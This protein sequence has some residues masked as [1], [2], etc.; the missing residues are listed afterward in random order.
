MCE[1]GSHD[2]PTTSQLIDWNN[3]TLKPEKQT[4]GLK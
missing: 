3:K 4:D 2:V 1:A